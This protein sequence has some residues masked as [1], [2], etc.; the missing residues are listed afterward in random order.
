[1]INDK[2][3]V[4]KKKQTAIAQTAKRVL[5]PEESGENLALSYSSGTLCECYI[6]YSVMSTGVL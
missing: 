2:S 5:K 3:M 6:L 4:K 1:M